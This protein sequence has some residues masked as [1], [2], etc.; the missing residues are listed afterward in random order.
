MTPV[1]TLL[2][3]I[4]IQPADELAWL[5]LA[6]ALEESGE[7]LRAELVRLTRSLRT[8]ARTKPE[9]RA[10][11]QRVQQLLAESVLPCIPTITNSIGMRLVLIP[12]GQFK[13]GSPVR[14]MGRLDHEPLRR[15]SIRRVFWMSAHLVTQ[16]QYAAL[17]RGNPGVYKNHQGRNTIDWPAENMSWEQARA[18]CTKLSNRPEEKA[19]LRRYRL[20]T[21]EEW[22]YACRAWTTSAFHCGPRLTSLLAN[23]DNEFAHPTPVGQYPPNPWGLYDMHGNLWE[24]CVLVPVD[25]D[26]QQI[27]NALRGGAFRDSEDGCRSAFRTHQGYVETSDDDVGFRVVMEQL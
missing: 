20:P 11:E 19:A 9:R 1:E 6:D 10:T 7:P 21:E 18:F 8:L 17:M 27:H 15:I 4:A 23:F 24:K 25:N 16:G 13:I 14:E 22:E 3:A 12:P 2:S 5:A 26:E